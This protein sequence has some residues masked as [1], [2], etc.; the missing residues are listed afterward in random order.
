MQKYQWHI[1]WVVCGVVG[2]VLSVQLWRLSPLY[3]D[4]SLRSRTQELIQATATREGWL[5]SGLVIKHVTQNSV[6]L[7]YRSYVRGEDT[8]DC[9]MLSLDSGTL[10]PCMQ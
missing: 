5:L 7:Q 2:F 10:S 6:Q 3:L 4:A 9:Y 1:F 8:I